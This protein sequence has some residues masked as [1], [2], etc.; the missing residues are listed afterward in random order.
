MLESSKLTNNVCKY[1]ERFT[2]YV[3]VCFYLFLT[4]VVAIL[5]Y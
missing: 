1:S 5:I 4:V 2:F 3:F